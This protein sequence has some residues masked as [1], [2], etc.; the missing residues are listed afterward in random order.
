MGE[1]EFDLLMNRIS[2][3]D[4]IEK[5][6]CSPEPIML[7]ELNNYGNYY[8]ID[9]KHRLCF[10]KKNGIRQ[11]KAYLFN[12][13]ELELFL[14]NSRNKM[15]YKWIQKLLYLGCLLSQ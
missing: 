10:A 7:M 8:I 3:E 6:K 13:R 2:H 4:E 9:E 15:L 12:S 1:N 14:L 5:F 11:I